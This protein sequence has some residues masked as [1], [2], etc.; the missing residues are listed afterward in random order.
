[1][2]RAPFL[3][4]LPALLLMACQAS[5]PARIP[6]AESAPL[7]AAAVQAEEH[8]SCGAGSEHCGGSDSCCTQ[9]SAEQVAVAAAGLRLLEDHSQICMVRD[10]F[11]GRPQLPVVVG[12]STYYGCCAGCVNRL[13]ADARARAA[14]DPVSGRSIDKALAVVG[15]NPRG[16]LVYFES[17]E[18]FRAYAALLN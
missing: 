3:P 17:A 6:E 12:S 4:A 7:V 18:N 5:A 14:I 1:M 15:V 16:G 11:M 8:E 13:V 10:H 2:K 9:Q